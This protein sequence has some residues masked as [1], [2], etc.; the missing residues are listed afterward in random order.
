MTVAKLQRNGEA[1]LL[2]ALTGL[3]VSWRRC[4]V[5]KRK[6][7]RAVTDTLPEHID[8]TPFRKFALQPGKKLS[9][10]RTIFI[11]CEGFGQL[12]LRGA[13]KSGEL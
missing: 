10:G 7:V 5:E 3:N 2:E 1:V 4:A 6:L 13:Q 12:G 9:P 8:D 11:K